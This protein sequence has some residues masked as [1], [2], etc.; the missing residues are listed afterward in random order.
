[1]ELMFIKSSFDDTRYILD[2][3]NNSLAYFYKDRKSQ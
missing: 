3:E 2:D 1:M